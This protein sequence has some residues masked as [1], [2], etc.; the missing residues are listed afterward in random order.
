MSKVIAITRD[1]YQQDLEK[2]MKATTRFISA[3]KL[4]LAKDCPRFTS[5]SG[6]AELF[7]VNPT[8]VYQ[9]IDS[10]ELK[11]MNV[12]TGK[13]PTYRVYRDHLAAFFAERT[14]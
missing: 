13:R 12:G 9:W 8:L 5:V 6:I 4:D 14:A 7:G 11:A 1:W 2:P 3:E 10:G